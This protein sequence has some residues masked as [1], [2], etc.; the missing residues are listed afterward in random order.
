MAV[1]FAGGAKEELCRTVP[2]KMCC[3]TAE[4]FGILL[5]ANC[6]SREQIRIVTESREFAWHLPQVFDRAFGIDFDSFEKHL[7]YI[8]MF[9]RNYPNSGQVKTMLSDIDKRIEEWLQP[10]EQ[11]IKVLTLGE[12][13]DFATR[14]E[15]YI[16]KLVGGSVRAMVAV[17]VQIALENVGVCNYALRVISRMIDSVADTHEKQEVIEMV[18]NKLAN[19]PNS[20]YNQL[21]LQNMTYT[22][23]KANN[24]CNRYIIRLCQLV[25]EESAVP[26]WNNSWLKDDLIQQLPY[27]SI[28]DKETL[29]K[30]TPV[31][32]FR[33]R[34][35]YD[36]IGY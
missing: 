6:F 27:D 8:L 23:D 21:W 28:V 4:C 25:M 14:T 2:H 7:L 17:A 9:A 12:D 35:A 32:T 11:E 29:K 22:Q 15:T 16:R 19:T 5:F 13:D 24:N 31:I 30:V 1:S 18:Y 34:R 26:L 20:T 33:E 36:E 10:Q 3:A